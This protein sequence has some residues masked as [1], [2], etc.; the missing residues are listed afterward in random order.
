MSN[1]Y[2]T[3]N[4]E[5]DI[6]LS[7]NSNRALSVFFYCIPPNAPENLPYQH[8][9]VCLAEGLQSMGV[10]IHAS[11]N[12]WW[13]FGQENSFLF[14]QDPD[15]KPEDC[16]ILV[17]NGIWM[18]RNKFPKE[19]FS[20]GRK[21]I[22]VYIDSDD[23]NRTYA[24]D[25]E[26]RNFDFVLKSHYT[27]KHS[28]PS[29]FHPWYFGLS[30]RIIEATQN[31]PNFSD[32][33]IELLVN[34]RLNNQ[35]PHSV[36]VAANDYFL[37]QISSILPV[38]RSTDAFVQPPFNPSDYLQWIQTGRRHYPAYY[39]RL[40]Y[41]AACACFGGYFISDFLSDPS[42]RLSRLSKRWISKLRLKT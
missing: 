10:S 12:S 37:P 22:T 4:I 41:S 27:L 26:A 15:I 14:N 33:T 34:Y 6:T 20:Q 8:D 32:R 40:K 16:S 9:L 36:R 5:S 29:N 7:S 30:N 1:L 25:S 18:R 2:L 42:S 38:N 28:Y 31:I 13:L 21:Y 19:L 35:F 23:G 24:W 39:Q 17:F 3:K 11:A